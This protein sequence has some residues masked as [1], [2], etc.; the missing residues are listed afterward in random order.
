MTLEAGVAHDLAGGVI[1]VEFHGVLS[2]R[3]APTARAI[4]ITCLAQCPDAVLVGLH[5]LKVE[6]RS[7]LTMFPE[8]VRSAGG[9]PVAL[10][11]FGASP[12]VAAIMLGGILGG[13]CAHPDLDSARAA[14]AATRLADER[15]RVI[16]L[17][18]ESTAPA[19]ARSL[20]AEAC[21]DFDLDHLRGPATLVI[22]EF[23]SNAVQHAGTD[24][25]VRVAR[26]GDYL[27][28][29]VHDGS[30][31]APRVPRTDDCDGRPAERGRGLHLVD[32]Y[33]SAWG[34]NVD[35]TGKTVWATLRATPAG[36]AHRPATRLSPGHVPASS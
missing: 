25:V 30:S 36:A 23:V 15:R 16:R 6:S 22:S 20:I 18:P 4:L 34:S 5:D 24:V 28:L 7:R 2:A 17:A 10:L 3:S 27:H 29:S 8:A 19:R 11:L 21:R 26:R 14:V 12:E 9:P 1:L 35:D 33:T 31:Q 32:V 13:V